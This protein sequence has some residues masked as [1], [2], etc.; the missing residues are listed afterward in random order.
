MATISKRCRCA[1]RAIDVPQLRG[2]FLAGITG[3]GESVTPRM[4]LPPRISRRSLTA[5]LLAAP[6]AAGHAAAPVP[7]TLTPQDTL[8]LQR[9]ATYLNNIRTMTARFQ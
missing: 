2:H 9:I 3:A 1:I 6:V 7:A 5:L 4:I 8:A